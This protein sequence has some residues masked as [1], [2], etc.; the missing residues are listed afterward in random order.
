MLLDSNTAA[1]AYAG[2]EEDLGL[3][4]L[5]TASCPARLHFLWCVYSEDTCQKQS[6]PS[7][8]KEGLV[9]WPQDKSPREQVFRP[10]PIAQW[11]FCP[12]PKGYGLHQ[13]ATDTLSHL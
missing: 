2:W 6:S 7:S 12:H 11:E 13:P 8:R 9:P 1:F 4:P 3:V 10:N 5:S